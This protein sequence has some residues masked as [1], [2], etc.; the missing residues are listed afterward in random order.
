MIVSLSLVIIWS[1]VSRWLGM[2]SH[3]GGGQS[4]WALPRPSSTCCRSRWSRPLSQECGTVGESEARGRTV[5]DSGTQGT[6]TCRAGLRLCRRW[7]LGWASESTWKPVGIPSDRMCRVG[8]RGECTGI[9]LQWGSCVIVCLALIRSLTRTSIEQKHNDPDLP[10][11]GFAK[12][13]QHWDHA[14][15]NEQ[16][17]GWAEVEV[18]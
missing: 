18:A 11:L 13:V 2:R 3:F 4:G 8:G 9:S 15:G 16:Q 5:P 6:W 14:T 17:C 7:P 10:E 12:F 1:V